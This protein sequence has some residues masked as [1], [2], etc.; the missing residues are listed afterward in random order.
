MI[1][2]GNLSDITFYD[3]VMIV[4]GLPPELRFILAVVQMRT[5]FLADDIWIGFSQLRKG[6][7]RSPKNEQKKAEIYDGVLFEF[8]SPP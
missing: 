1:A 4:F 3:T 5:V 7:T 8:S 6:I 2:R